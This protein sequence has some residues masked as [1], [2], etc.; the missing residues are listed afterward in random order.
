MHWFENCH[1]FADSLQLSFNL[2]VDLAICA[3]NDLSEVREV[4]APEARLV[5]KTSDG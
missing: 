4:D 3:S 1:S 2:V 5:K